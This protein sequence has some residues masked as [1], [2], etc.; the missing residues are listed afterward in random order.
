M[1]NFKKIL[2]ATLLLCSFN[3]CKKDESTN[4]ETPV[5]DMSGTGKIVIV[6]NNIVGTQPLVFNTSSYTNESGQSFTVSKLIYYVSNVVLTKTDGSTTYVVLESY[7]L[8]DHANVTSLEYEI[9]DVPAGDYNNISFTIG[10]DS[11]RNCSGAQT[12]ALDPSNGMFW[13]WNTGYIFLKMEGTFTTT[14][15][16]SGSFIYH[17][18]GYKDPINCI[19]SV[20]MDFN[21]DIANV[22]QTKTPEVHMNCDV[23]EMLK[24]N[25]TID[26]DVLNFTMGDAN[27]KTIAN[28][29]RDMFKVDHVHND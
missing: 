2:F 17:I 21:G 20:T 8:I 13:S 3:A 10:V 25:T 18:G 14:L 11:T 22:R 6:F 23:L 28:N 9:E 26:F 15:N 5:D 4:D 1:K 7:H 12:G 24:T 19:R 16:P 27:S 29:Y